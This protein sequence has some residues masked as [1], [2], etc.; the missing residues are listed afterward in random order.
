MFK[1]PSVQILEYPF[2]ETVSALPKQL[3]SKAI[4]AWIRCQKKKDK[5]NKKDMMLAVPKVKKAWI[6]SHKSQSQQFLGLAALISLERKVN[7]N[8]YQ[9]S[10]MLW[11][12]Y[13]LSDSVMPRL[14]S[15]NIFITTS[16]TTVV[17]FV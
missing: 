4:T 10:I 14:S 6:N 9:A 2:Q 3:L 13:L 1:N 5:D 12:F 16:K 15:F 7:V 8:K 17:E 11:L